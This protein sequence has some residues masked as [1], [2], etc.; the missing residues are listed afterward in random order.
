VQNAEGAH[1]AQGLADSVDLRGVTTTTDADA[2][3]DTSE[4]LLAEDE[5]GL[6]NLW[7]A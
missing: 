6:K 5:Q 2:D 4:L 3:V 7:S 1:L